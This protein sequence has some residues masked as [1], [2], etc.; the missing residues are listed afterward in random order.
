[1]DGMIRKEKRGEQEK[2]CLVVLSRRS[3]TTTAIQSLIETQRTHSWHILPR[4]QE[5]MLFLR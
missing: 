4:V 1:M 3:S 2:E 5:M